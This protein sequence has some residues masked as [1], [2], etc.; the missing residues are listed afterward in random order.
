MYYAEFETDK[1]IRETFYPDK[2]Q[3]TMVEV[4]AG[5]P[6]FYSMSKHFR[7]TGWRCICVDPNPKFVEQH[8]IANNEIYQYACSDKNTTSTFKIVKAGWDEKNNG[9]GYS[10]LDV[11]YNIDVEHTIE[12]ITVDVITLNDLLKQL[13]VQAVDFVSIDTEGWELEVMKGFDTELFRPEII[14]LE[15][16]LHDKEYVE[17]MKNI[18]YEL[19]K[20]IEYN[21]I[22]IRK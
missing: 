5:P 3:G 21:Y 18:N 17:Y 4:G 6:V 8:Q 15:N 1:F 2:S 7:D 19:F 14:L 12:E 10:A 9:I 22:F 13:K 16:Y 20:Q 11:K